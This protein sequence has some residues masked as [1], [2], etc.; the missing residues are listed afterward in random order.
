M[1]ESLGP[2]QLF[3]SEVAA[4]PGIYR[5]LKQQL[6]RHGAALGLTPS[7]LSPHLRTRVLL[8][9]T[10]YPPG[11]TRER[12]IDLARV[13]TP[14]RARMQPS[15]QLDGPGRGVD[16]AGVSGPAMAVAGASP[17][18][19][20]HNVAMRFREPTSKF[21]GAAG[22][23][24]SEYVSEY[25]SMARDYEL[26]P[27]QR[28]RF[29]HNILAGDAKRFY[30]NN[31]QGHAAT[32]SEAVSMVEAEYNSQVKQMQV[33]NRLAS[34]RMS[35]H[36]AAGQTEAEALVSTYQLILRLAPQL[37][38]SHR[39]DP[40]KVDFLRSAVVGSAW[41]TEPLSRVATRGLGF[42]QLYGQL[43][44]AL[45]LHAEAQQ[46]AIAD[47]SS[48]R[49]APSAVSAT[50]P[51]V[52][53]A[54]VLYANQAMY[55]RPNK[56]IGASRP[57]PSGG[58][59][60]GARSGGATPRSGPSTYDGKGGSGRFDPLSVTGCFNCD[61]PGHTMRDC[62]L[63][64]NTVKA[65]Q[66]RLAYYSKKREGRPVAAAILFALCQQLD[67]AVGA[68]GEMAAPPSMDV[69]MMDEAEDETKFFE[70]LMHDGADDMSGVSGFTLGV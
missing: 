30:L 49:P 62:K 64:P 54:D 41:A 52:L 22:Q 58:G 48:G 9:E 16:A 51:R 4:V 17:D 23:T 1:A 47:D 6:D 12:A 37:P 35:A 60:G 2:E 57:G 31:V 26:S 69:H 32:F 39:A 7:H 34:H 18:R 70:S 20:A 28:F 55:G 24:W 10:V 66:R 46:A 13:V 36:V 44:A 42:Q 11:E 56:G 19:V 45:Q 15:H 61:H 38:V 40:H 59:S 67:A 27:D 21:S 3:D 53:T 68:D 29:L 33:K 25:Q 65:A 8:A 5:A 14:P 43:E 50:V 63:P